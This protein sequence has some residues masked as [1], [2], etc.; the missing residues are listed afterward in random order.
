[1]GN[2]LF[3]YAFTFSESKRKNVLFSFVIDPYYKFYLQDYIK[4]RIFEK[5]RIK[6]N[7]LLYWLNLK[8]SV[9]FRHVF[10]EGNETATEI[11]NIDEINVFYEG[12]FQSIK[13]FKPYKNEIKKLFTIKDQYVKTF[14]NKYSHIF[15]SNKEIALIHIRRTDYINFGDD[16]LGGKDLTLPMTYYENCIK[17]LEKKENIQFIVISDD[18]NF[19]I[20]YFGEKENFHFE[21]NSEIIDF[22][23]IMN[24]DYLIIS[25]SS[26]AWWGAFLNERKKIVFAP[27]YWL[28]FKILKDYPSEITADLNWKL[29]DIT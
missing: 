10:Q 18:L 4:L 26:F 13:Y 23:L 21:K 25:N 15:N 29:I 24:S 2:Q 20:D 12:Y 6:L 11:L 16:D 5:A 14:N 19:V 1:M 8:L 17:E 7:K 9:K 22:Q 28:G 3:Q 27:N